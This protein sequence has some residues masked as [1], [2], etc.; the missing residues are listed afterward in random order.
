MAI[1]GRIRFSAPGHPFKGSNNNLFYQ[2]DLNIY[3]ISCQVFLARFFEKNRS[4]AGAMK[5]RNYELFSPIKAK[6]GRKSPELERKQ[7][8]VVRSEIFPLVSPCSLCHHTK[9]ECGSPMSE[10]RRNHED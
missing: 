6:P 1:L 7:D 2:R 10:K 5:G 3:A 9:Q 8:I 4:V